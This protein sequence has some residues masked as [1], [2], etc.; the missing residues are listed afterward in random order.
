MSRVKIKTGFYPCKNIDADLLCSN[1]TA[2]QRLCFRYLDSTIVQFQ[3]QYS[4]FLLRLYRPVCVRP[5][6]KPRRPIFSRCGSNDLYVLVF[7]Y[8]ENAKRPSLKIS[9][10]IQ[11]C[12]VTLDATGF[13]RQSL[14]VS[15]YHY[16]WTL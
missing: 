3:F 11:R 1:C 12:G 14:W 5:G 6:R 9:K 4:H 10:H 16:S 7:C 15:L 2:D 13:S 8:Y